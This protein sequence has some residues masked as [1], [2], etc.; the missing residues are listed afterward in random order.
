M[1]AKMITTWMEKDYT[2]ANYSF[3]AMYIPKREKKLFLSSSPDS[4]I[5]F[6][7]RLPISVG[8]TWYYVNF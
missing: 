4:H 2:K 7:K 6:N 3:K 8:L 1:I 5:V